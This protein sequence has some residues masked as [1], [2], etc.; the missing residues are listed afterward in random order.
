MGLLLMWATLPQV[1]Q[2]FDDL[3]QEAFAFTGQ[4]LATR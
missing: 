3:V 1:L 2:G 4:V